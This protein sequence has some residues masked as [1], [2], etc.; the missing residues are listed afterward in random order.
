MSLGRS[1]DV[2]AAL[3]LE[4][5][6]SPDAQ[7]EFR[8]LRDRGV[9]A[10]R[11][12]DL[13]GALDLFDR[14]AE[15]ARASGD[16]D[17]ADLAHCNRA[18][19]AIELGDGSGVLAE[20]RAILLRSRSAQCCMVAATNAARIHDLAKDYKKGL[21]YAR[22]ARDHAE[23]GGDASQLA[24]VRNLGANLLL[25]ESH[26][27]EAAR[28]YEA[29]LELMPEDDPVWRARALGNL[30]YC[31][32]LQG[33]LREAF[34]LL[35]QS[36]DP[37]RRLEARLYLVSPLTDLAFAHLEAGHPGPAR[38]AAEEALALARELADD[39]GIKNALYLLGEAAGQL[40]D[41][42]L[43]R[44]TFLELQRSY[45]PDKPFVCDFLLSVDVRKIVNLRA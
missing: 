29:A 16:T 35:R 1:M 9:E 44:S 38:N 12:G 45:Y 5:Q 21:F 13:R 43:A 30:G 33:R 6:E 4:A 15:R 36:I 26:V 28:E 17:L 27:E 42:Q 3:E 39:A 23:A 2:R 37:L 31:R 19:I 11:A 32:V 22:L 10:L 8:V 18:A 24:S 34:V 41:L 40:G 20:M 14:A 7:R 25:A